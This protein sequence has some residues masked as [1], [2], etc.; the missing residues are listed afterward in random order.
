VWLGWLTAAALCFALPAA[1]QPAAGTLDALRASAEITN[2]VSKG[3]VGAAAAAA[4]RLMEGPSAEKLKGVFQAVRDLG[5]AQYTDLIYDRDYGQTEKDVIYKIDFDK[6]FVFVRYLY[7]I[8]NGAWRLIHIDLKT[9]NDLP[10]PKDW[11]HIYPK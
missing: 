6:A 4:S 5:R 7:H 3:D 11:A 10:F 1:A 2:D 8:D 9:E